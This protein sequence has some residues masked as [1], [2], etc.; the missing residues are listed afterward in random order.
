MIG[1]ACCFCQKVKE[2]VKNLIPPPQDNY[3]SLGDVSLTDIPL[4]IATSHVCLP[5]EQQQVIVCML[6][7]GQMY[8]LM[9][10]CAVMCPDFNGAS[11]IGCPKPP[12]VILATSYSEQFNGRFTKHLFKLFQHFSRLVN[13]YLYIGILQAKVCHDTCGPCCLLSDNLVI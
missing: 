3:M 10:T 7:L 4:Y 2:G 1:G 12:N 6:V 5:L 11:D 8:V 9:F 13:L